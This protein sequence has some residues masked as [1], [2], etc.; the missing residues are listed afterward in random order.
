M[1]R[2]TFLKNS[3]TAGLVTLIMPSGIVQ[4]ATKQTNSDVKAAEALVDAFVNP[5][6]SARAQVWWHW[7]NG[8][9]TADG[10]TRDLEAMQQIGIGGFQNFDA[11]TGIPKGPVVYL[12]P[13]W[14]SLKQHAMKEAD[15]L[16]LE[17]TMHNC[18]GWSSSGGPWITPELA[19]QEVTWSEAYIAGGQAVSVTLSRPLSKL[20][21]YRDV[22]VLAF[23][24]LPGEDSLITLVNKATTSGNSE[25]V[26][27]D[28]LARSEGVAIQPAAGGSLLIF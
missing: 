19:M 17:F 16:G 18:P 25:P 27:L 5:P 8:N 26:A 9:V 4:V 28:K 3:S 20:D 21:F 15:R 23:P 10:I 7:M 2:R 24:S 1:R 22:A 6:M 13:E 11:G 12:S 14:L